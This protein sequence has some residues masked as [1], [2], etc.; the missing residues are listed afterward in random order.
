MHKRSR[1]QIIKSSKMTTNMEPSPTIKD[2]SINDPIYNQQIVVNYTK[3]QQ[4]QNIRD[5][6]AVR[7]DNHKWAR[8]GL[9]E[10]H[11]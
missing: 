10:T 3:D 11:E 5:E 7:P 2:P 8:N 9:S 1:L 4:G 6:D